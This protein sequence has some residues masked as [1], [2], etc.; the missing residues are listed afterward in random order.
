MDQTIF[1][2][3][4]E[5][6]TLAYRSDIAAAQIGDTLHCLPGIYGGHNWQSGTYDA[7]RHLLFC[8]C[9]NCALI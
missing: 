2:V 1:E 9:T 3:D 8:R 5:A 7:T 4:R 6:G